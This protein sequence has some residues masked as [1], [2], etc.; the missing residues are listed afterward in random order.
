MSL[1]KFFSP[2]RAFRDLREFISH[3]QRHELVF[4]VI[5]IGITGSVIAAFVHDSKFETPYKR[6]VVYVQNW[7]LDRTD[8][9]IRAQQI[10]DQI[11]K[12]QRQAEFKRKQD[13]RRAEFQRLDDKLDK[14]GL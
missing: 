5:S 11:K 3:R 13:A 4:L 8:E 7:R 9:E 14:W 1:L 2:T 6:E 12:E 10:I